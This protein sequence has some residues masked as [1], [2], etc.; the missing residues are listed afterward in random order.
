M[1]LVWVLFLATAVEALPGSGGRQL[2]GKA[3]GGGAD[4]ALIRKQMAKKRKTCNK[5]CLP[6][7][8]KKYV[9]CICA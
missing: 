1:L 7:K 5:S 2:M 6:K 9:P 4:Q 3:K 8:A